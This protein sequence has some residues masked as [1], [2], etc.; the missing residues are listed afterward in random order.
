VF[1]SKEFAEKLDA[2]IHPDVETQFLELLSLLEQQELDSLSNPDLKFEDL[3]LFQGKLIMIR[4][5]KQY[6]QRII[7]SVEQ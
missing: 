3:K 1:F 6:K 5:L 7:D 4:D 2:L